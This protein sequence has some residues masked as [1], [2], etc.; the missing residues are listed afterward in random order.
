MWLTIIVPIFHDDPAVKQ[1]V[2]ELERWGLE[3]VAVV[4]VDGEQRKR[5]EWLP[6]NF[7]YSNNGV[8][9][10]GQQLRLGGSVAQSP[11]LLFLHADSRF[12]I[13]SPL[14]VLRETTAKVG[15]FTLHFNDK[16]RFFRVIAWGSNL[17]AR[18][19]KLIFGDQ[20]LFVTK[21]IY[22]KSGGFPV[23]PLMED[24]EFSR[25]L[26][27][28]DSEF[29]QFPLPILTSARKYNREGR[30]KTFFKMQCLKLLYLLG[31]SPTILSRLYYRRR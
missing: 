27:K 6:Q 4:I 7:H 23:Q 14:P 8:P 1:L 21:T 20:G 18:K 5:P 31:F 9:N 19:F 24:F 22:E 10:R 11:K 25:R 12:P 30:F 28:V 26:A 3:H 15:F 2:V 17:R 13:G 29:I 16:S